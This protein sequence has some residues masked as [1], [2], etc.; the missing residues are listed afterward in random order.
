MITVKVLPNIARWYGH[1]TDIDYMPQTA[2]LH[3]VTYQ[4]FLVW[5]GNM[6]EDLDRETGC[7]YNAE[8][9]QYWLINSLRRQIAN[10]KKI[11]AEYVA[12]VGA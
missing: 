1:E 9:R 6:Q 11:Q 8:D 12:K 7:G 3:I 5:L 2:G 10:M 4:K